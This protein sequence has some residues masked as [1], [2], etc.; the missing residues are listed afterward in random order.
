MSKIR[1]SYDEILNYLKGILSYRE[2]HDLERKM[3]QDPFDEEAFEG[4]SGLTANE[5]EA[6]ME[7][8]VSRLDTRVQKDKKIRMFPV[9]RIAAAV[10]FLT[11]IGALLI[12]LLKA[13]APELITH[14]TNRLEQTSPAETAIPAVPGPV[15]LAEPEKREE[16]VEVDKK[17]YA[18][19]SAPEEDKFVIDEIISNHTIESNQ[20][21][22]V[23]TESRA[24]A[25]KASEPGQQNSD[26]SGPEYGYISGRVLGI[27][28][29]ALAGVSITEEGTNQSTSTDING[30]FSL[31]VSDP[32]S[33]LELSYQGYMNTEVASKEIA[34]KE[35][36]LDD[37]LIAQ[38]ELVVLN[39]NNVKLNRS[40]AKKDDAVSV[41]KSAEIY[42]R[43]VPPGGSMK[44]FEGWVENRIDTVLLKELLPGK[45]IIRV[46]LTVHKDGTIGNISVP[47]D[48]PEVAA[49]QYLYA[50]SLTERW[51][52][53]MADNLP[54][55]SDI[56]IEF[57]LIVK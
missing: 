15:T 31:K 23:H 40:A 21:S 6:D 37:E 36:S 43:P 34:G 28:R 1:Q 42:R 22:E 49:K 2:R 11:G 57:S 39:Y 46:K 52:P 3:M 10:L 4:L 14:E 27:N 7:S 53:A 16:S 38:Q 18:E 50:V 8:L 19:P 33:K 41:E 20:E 5:L 13:P 17:S 55:D 48:I 24:T 32:D 47:D 12:F 9:W 35:I 54:I 30:N 45:Y 25:A 26:T 56:I 51:Q 29:K 44:N